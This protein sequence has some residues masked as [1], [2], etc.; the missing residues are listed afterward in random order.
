VLL[1][2]AGRKRHKSAKLIDID[3][4]IALEIIEL[5]QAIN[6]IVNIIQVMLVNK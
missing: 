2:I 5:H 4:T 6:N 3:Q 1:Q